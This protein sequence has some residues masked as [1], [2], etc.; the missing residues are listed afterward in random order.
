MRDYRYYRPLAGNAMNYAINTTCRGRLAAAISALTL[1]FIP[2]VSHATPA[3]DVRRAAVDLYARMSARDL[4][5]VLQY[6]PKDGFT[7]IDIGASGPHRLDAKA[8]EGLFQVPVD[9]AL[10]ATDLD[11]H[12][13]G[14]TAVVTGKRVGAVVPK[15]KPAME[16]VNPFTAVWVNVG[17]HWQLQHTHLSAIAEPTR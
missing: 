6:V 13:W 3:D 5:G 16:S 12:T 17:G 8:F 14:D 9:I 1:T 7:E 10:R 11:V 4:P 15:G 2:L